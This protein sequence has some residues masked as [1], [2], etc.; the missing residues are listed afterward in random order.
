MTGLVKITFDMKT[1]H[2]SMFRGHSWLIPTWLYMDFQNITLLFFFQ[3]IIV[4]FGNVQLY[5][6][7]PSI[8]ISSA[9]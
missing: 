3:N 5:L 4:W 8:E 1:C 2:N 7:D 6:L 9:S